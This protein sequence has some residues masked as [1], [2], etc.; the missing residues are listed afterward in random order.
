MNYYPAPPPQQDLP[1]SNEGFNYPTL[2]E[3]P[4]GFILP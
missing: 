4:A 3:Q 1:I 2:M